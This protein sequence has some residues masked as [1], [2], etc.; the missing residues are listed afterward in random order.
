MSSGSYWKKNISLQQ[1]EH[2]HALSV[3]YG[4]P[5]GNLCHEAAQKNN[6]KKQFFFAICM[7]IKI[8]ILY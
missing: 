3:E 8:S 5:F 6:V 7:W 2:W 1:K 4:V